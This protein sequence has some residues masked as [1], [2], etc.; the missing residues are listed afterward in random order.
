MGKRECCPRGKMGRSRCRVV[1]ACGN[2][3]WNPK[4]TVR[5]ENVVQVSCYTGVLL[6]LRGRECLS[7]PPT[8]PVP[9]SNPVFSPFYL[10]FLLLALFVGCISNNAISLTTL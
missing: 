7:P 5:R 1:V 6:F 8:P 3:L 10:F 2:R 9:S 4:H